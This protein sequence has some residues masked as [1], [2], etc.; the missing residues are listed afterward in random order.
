MFGDNMKPEALINEAVKKTLN[1]FKE[2]YVVLILGTLVAVLLMMFV[3][4]IP[5]LIF[6][7]YYMCAQVMKGRKAEVADVFKGF[8]YFFRSWWLMILAACA[9]LLGLILLI[10]P[11]L[12][13]IVLFQY[14]IA[15]SILEN[16]S[17]V[18]SLKKSY[19]IGKKNFTF[20]AVVFILMAVLN[21]LGGMTHIGILITLPLQ[22]LFICIAAKKLA[23]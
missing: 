5:P 8:N 9:V 22:S 21:S 7:I 2:Q 14:A 4:T 10:I 1:I 17:A 20:S 3:V 15:I 6:G 12:L 23:A 18:E 19:A 13:L 11:G 16:K